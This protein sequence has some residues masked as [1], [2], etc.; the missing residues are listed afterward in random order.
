MLLRCYRNTLLGTYRFVAA[1][2]RD[3]AKLVLS[4]RQILQLITACA[5]T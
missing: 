3:Y 4:R 1:I 5:V 2:E